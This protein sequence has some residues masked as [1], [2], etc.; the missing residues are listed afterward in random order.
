[1]LVFFAEDDEDA[2]RLDQQMGDLEGAGEAVDERLWNEEEEND[3]VG[4]ACT[5]KSCSVATACS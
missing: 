4:T 3:Q 2:E 5:S 1:M